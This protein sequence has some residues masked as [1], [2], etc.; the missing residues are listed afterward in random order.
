MVSSS[1][2]DSAPSRSALT[3][4]A[5]WRCS[6]RGHLAFEGRQVLAARGPR[7]AP[8]GSV[9]ACTWARASSG[10]VV[11]QHR[12]PSGS[13]S[14]ASSRLDRTAPRPRARPHPGRP[15][16]SSATRAISAGQAGRLGLEGGDHVDVGRRIQGGHDGAA[17]LA[18]HARGPPGP[19]DQPLDP[20]QGAG[21]VLLAARGQLGRG[22]GGLRIER[23]EGRVELVLLV[24]ADGQ[25]VR[26]P[27]GAGL[28]S[29]ASSAPAR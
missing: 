28:D 13:R 17:P 22:G 14:A 26:R 25:V 18:Q 21:Q 8:R 27:S 20:A 3:A 19:L 11:A 1:A 7:P 24:A 12:R 6:S 29:S 16:V 2:A 15:P 4:A 10:V 9:R 5:A 23:L